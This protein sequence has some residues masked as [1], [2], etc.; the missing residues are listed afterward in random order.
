MSDNAAT[1]R[2]SEPRSLAGFV[3]AQN[4]ALASFRETMPLHWSLLEDADAIFAAAMPPVATVP[5]HAYP[6]LVLADEAWRAFLN[7]AS[8]AARQQ[9]SEPRMF[10]RRGS[11]AAL[12]ALRITRHAPAS[13]EYKIACDAWLKRIED[14]PSFDRVFTG[15]AQYEQLGELAEQLYLVREHTSEIGSHANANTA[16]MHVQAGSEGVF[17][18]PFAS[19]SRAV[20]AQCMHVAIVNRWILE[21]VLQSLQRVGLDTQAAAARLLAYIV[22]LGAMAQAINER[23]SRSAAEGQSPAGVVGS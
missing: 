22:R 15:R 1:G 6:I 5:T 18:N 13:D 20:E 2:L 12:Y 21:A 11:E 10:C 14:K 17:T 4:L 16:H 19:S 7:A 3:A 8:L 9:A 23:Q